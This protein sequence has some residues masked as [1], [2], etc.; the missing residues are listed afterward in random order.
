MVNS[1]QCTEDGGTAISVNFDDATTI[2]TV[3]GTSESKI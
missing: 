1:V 3:S 2:K